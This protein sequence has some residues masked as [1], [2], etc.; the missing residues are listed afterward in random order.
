MIESLKDFWQGWIGFGGGNR[1]SW[2]YLLADILLVAIVCFVVIRAF[3]SKRGVGYL[4][5]IGLA[6]AVLIIS[7]YLNLPGLHTVSQFGIVLLVIGLPFYFRDRWRALVG[8]ETA[9]ITAT[10]STTSYLNP[11]TIGLLSIITS[12]LVV[13][14]SSGLG[15]KTAE[16]P[17]GVPLVAVNL[18]DGMAASFGSQVTVRVIVRAE[19]NQ[20]QS[21]TADTF[22]ATIDVAHQ[23][24]GTYDLPVTVTSKV[25]DIN[26]VRV[27][28]SR[29]VVTVEPIIRK[30]VTVSAKFTG[31]AGSELVPDDPLI[32]PMKVEASGPKS[33]LSDFS[34]AYI[35]VKLNGETQ[36]IVNKFGVTAL[37]TAGEVINS[38]KFIPPEVEATINLIKAGNLKTV[39]IRPVISDSPQNGYWVKS[40]TTE[41]QVINVTGS[42][43][44]LASLTQVLTGSISVAG[45]SADTTFSTTLDLPSGVTIADGSTG[46]ITAF[47]DLEESNTSKTI[48]PE[49]SY[50]GLSAGLK[51]VTVTP[52]LVSS[53]V[54]GTSNI[55]ANLADSSI[56]LKINLSPYQSAGTYSITLKGADFA[57]PD[58]VGLVSYLPSALS[59]V[60]ENR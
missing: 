27:N 18:P 12:F 50:D 57:F 46:K 55:L 49:L 45:L 44:S 7:A 30:T 9:N 10:Q 14:I 48:T 34:Q 11:L 22:S 39:G 32:E 19:T 54:S 4:A 5:L 3:N 35:Q 33:T 24:A 59:V 58:G 15:T 31:R 21:L 37:N 60:L 25:Q 42:I 40:I 29:V 51:V 43:E 17:N 23:T 20:W 52:A 53:L 13:G 8:A 38:I 26:T 1:S 6:I 16:L 41:P 47:A 36:K 56:K 28:P 2:F